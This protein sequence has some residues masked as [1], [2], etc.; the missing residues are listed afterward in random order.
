MLSRLTFSP[1]ICLK[2]AAEQDDV[3]S[4]FGNGN[5]S[6]SDF[7]GFEET[8]IPKQSGVVTSKK[9]SKTKQLAVTDKN[10]SKKASVSFKTK[11]TSG[12]TPPNVSGIKELANVNSHVTSSSKKNTAAKGK[13]VPN[14][15]KGKA[16]QKKNNSLDIADLSEVDISMLKNMLGI[17]DN[18]QVQP[19]EMEDEQYDY[20]F[21]NG[22][23]NLPKVHVEVE[24]EPCSDTEVFWKMTRIF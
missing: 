9:Q 20:L 11:Q 1:F 14:V 22:I 5:G 7:S 8:H 6:D 15:S 18:S 12:S 10:K 3:L 17:S 13:S 4:L 16:L 21:A 23:E 19:D 2:M 24:N